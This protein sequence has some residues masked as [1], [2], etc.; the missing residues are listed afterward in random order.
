MNTTISFRAD[1]HIKTLLEAFALKAHITKTQIINDAL[2]AYLKSIDDKITNQVS[3][4]NAIDN[5]E[6]YLGDEI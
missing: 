3:I 2:A 5:D 6:D 1:N 4:L